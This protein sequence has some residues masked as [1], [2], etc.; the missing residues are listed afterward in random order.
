MSTFEQQ[1]AAYREQRSM[2]APVTVI[3]HVNDFKSDWAHRPSDDICAGLRILS[4]EDEETAKTE[5]RKAAVES[6]G[7]LDEQP[8]K[9]Y[10]IQY[11]AM[12][13]CNP[14][15]VERHCD[16]FD[17]AS[18]QLPVALTSNALLKIYDAAER[19]KIETSPLYIE[20]T[21]DE[22]TDLAGEFLCGSI[23]DLT[24]VN[25]AK[26]ARVRRFAKLILDD[27]RG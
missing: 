15:D 26:A 11:C 1:A 3:L 25:R 22:L 7:D 10:L 21:D 14:N 5:A 27:L 4:A 9:H 18:D 17:M 16:P 2:R 8:K 20:A 13:L 19:L 12:S 23:D 24:A 6:D